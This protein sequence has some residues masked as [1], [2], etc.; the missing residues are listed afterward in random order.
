MVVARVDAGIPRWKQALLRLVIINACVQYC[1]VHCRG[2]WLCPTFYFQRV[3]W[4][5]K[6][7][8]FRLAIQSSITVLLLRFALVSLR[9][10][11]RCRFGRSRDTTQFKVHGTRIGVQKPGVTYCRIYKKYTTTNIYVYNRLWHVHRHIYIYIYMYARIQWRIAIIS[12][13]I[14]RSWP[15]PRCIAMSFMGRS[16]YASRIGRDSFGPGPALGLGPGPGPALGLGLCPC[17][18]PWPSLAL[19][20]AV[21]LYTIVPHG[22]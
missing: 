3:S 21:W 1:L 14:V 20:L 5:S 4:L 12:V 19:A 2:V 6:G 15:Q 16:R 11:C 8:E 7:P 9:D 18:L 17:P 10:N 13:W 22:L